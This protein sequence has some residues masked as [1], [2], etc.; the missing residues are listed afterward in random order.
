MESARTEIMAR[1]RG[2]AGDVKETVKM[3]GEI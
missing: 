3:K 2:E 1:K